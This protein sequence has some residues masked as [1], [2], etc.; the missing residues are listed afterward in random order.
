MEKGHNN[1]S[2]SSAASWY[3]EVESLLEIFLFIARSPLSSLL[4]PSLN[5]LLSSAAS[6]ADCNPASCA[7]SLRAHPGLKTLCQSPLEGSE[8][9]REG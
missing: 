6:S 9:G 4:F 1:Y 7:A 8:G 5:P 2:E 3:L